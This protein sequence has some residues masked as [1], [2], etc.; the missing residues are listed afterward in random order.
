MD[1]LYMPN[2]LFLDFIVDFKIPPENTIASPWG[3]VEFK[4]LCLAVKGTYNLDPICFGSPQSYHISMWTLHY[5]RSSLLGWP[6][7]QV[8]ALLPLNLY[9]QCPMAECAALL[10]GSAHPPRPS[11]WNIPALMVRHCLILQLSSCFTCQLSCTFQS[12]KVPTWCSR[13]C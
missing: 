9:S 7:Q 13:L 11:S 10:P 1:R 6:L 4:S 5:G 3:T 12:D 8:C 2:D